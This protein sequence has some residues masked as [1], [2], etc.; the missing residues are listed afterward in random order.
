MANDELA[1]GTVL[2]NYR[3]ERLLGRGGMGQ[4]YAATHVPLDKRVALK[5]LTRQFASEPSVVQRFVRE[6]RAAAR[7][8]HDHV[9]EVFDV[10]MIDDVPFLAME[11][12]EGEPLSQ[13]FARGPVPA[14]ELASLML[15][16]LDAVGTAHEMGIVH[17]DL[18]PD[19]IFLR[20]DARGLV[21]PV[22]LDFGISKLAEEASLHLTDTRAM[23]GTPYYMSPEQARGAKHVTGAT[24]QY[25]LAVLMYEGATGRRPFEGESLLEL[26]HK[27]TTG[28]F[29]RPE[30]VNRAVPVALADVI[31]RGMSLDVSA[32]YPT[33]WA[34]GLALMPLASARE[35]E[36]W[37]GVFARRTGGLATTVPARA[38]VVAG[39][40][41]TTMGGAAGAIEGR[42]RSARA[43]PLAIGGG[44]A[45][46]ALAVG[47]FAGMRVRPGDAGSSGAAGPSPSVSDARGPSVA[48][49]ASAVDAAAAAPVTATP[50]TAGGP[51]GGADRDPKKRQ[52]NKLH[53]LR[54]LSPNDF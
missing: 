47:L 42:R 44:I 14:D 22:V 10:G 17:R 24:D 28:T 16:I 53:G 18:K 21:Q 5:V 12:L 25:A 49:A 11:L 30:T 43:L 46:A 7:V 15:P 39:A 4:V 2:G 1:A 27:I 38:D 20:R 26:V 37:R 36:T 50:T 52:T 9:I 32:R 54:H 19:N 8:R 29:A 48:S 13:H 51:D 31:V 40:A 45:V 34:M 6:G 35:Q 41:T 23:M 33:L 3:V